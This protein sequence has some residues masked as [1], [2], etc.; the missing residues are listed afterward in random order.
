MTNRSTKL[1]VVALAVAAACS[2][3]ACGQKE[4]PKPAPAAASYY[5]VFSFA[6]TAYVNHSV[7]VQLYKLNFV[8]I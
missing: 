5:T 4:E 3:V 2:L 8:V 7:L 1:S 6:S